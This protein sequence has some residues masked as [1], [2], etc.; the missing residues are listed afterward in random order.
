MLSYEELLN[1]LAAGDFETADGLASFM[2]GRPEIEAEHDHP[3]DLCFGYTLKSFARGSRDEMMELA[4]RFS[5]ICEEA[6][7]VDFAGYD[8]GV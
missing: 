1:A 2:G 4:T 6:E 5:L 3:F 7:N 8:A